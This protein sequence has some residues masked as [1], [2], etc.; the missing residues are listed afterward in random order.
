MFVENGYKKSKRIRWVGQAACMETIIYE[1]KH[2]Q[3]RDHLID[4]GVDV[5]TVLKGALNK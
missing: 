3:E 2:C 4:L 5:R 1:H